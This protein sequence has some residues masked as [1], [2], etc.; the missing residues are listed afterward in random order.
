[1]TKNLTRLHVAKIY[2]VP[3][4]TLTSRMNGHIDIR[5]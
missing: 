3:Y 4:S 2:D 5:E 1:M